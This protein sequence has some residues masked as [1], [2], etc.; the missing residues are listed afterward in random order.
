[1]CS[2]RTSVFSWIM[3]ICGAWVAADSSVEAQ[4]VVYLSAGIDH[5]VSRRDDG[6]VW[7]WGDNQYGQLGD[8]TMVDRSNP[9][10]VVQDTGEPLEAVQAVASRGWHTVAIDNDKRLELE[11]ITVAA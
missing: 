3:M 6:T 11:L 10:Q 9:V 1:M 8:G 7:A 2:L 5:S 4:Q